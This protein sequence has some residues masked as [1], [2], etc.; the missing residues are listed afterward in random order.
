MQVRKSALHDLMK[1][2]LFEEGPGDTSP[3]QGPDLSQLE[4]MEDE[5]ITTVPDEFPVEPSAQM[6]TQLSEDRPP[7]ED[8]SYL[9]SNSKELGL[10]ADVIGQMV[11]DDQVEFFYRRL[12]MLLEDAVERHNNPDVEE[13]DIEEEVVQVKEGKLRMALRTLL[14]QSP[15]EYDIYRYGTDVPG[16]ESS[17]MDLPKAPEEPVS[18]D[19]LASQ[20]G[21][22]AA[23]GIRQEI[24]RI[25]KRLGFV[26]DNI[27]P[28]DLDLMIHE[29]VT[30]YIETLVA[31]GMI[32]ATDAADLVGS[33]QHVAELDS[34]RFFFTSAFIMPAYQKL[35][36]TVRKN[37]E[38]KVHTMG[39]PKKTQQTV[40]NQA[41]GE[42]PRNFA[43]LNK[44]L[45]KDAAAEGASSEEIEKMK[46]VLFKEFPKLVKLAS[47]EGDLAETALETWRGFTSSKKEKLLIQAMEATT[48]LQGSI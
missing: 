29:A 17:S 45:L 5:L 16:D 22:R 37:I 23:S 1:G 3:A 20:F 21:Y 6:A 24:E 18:L 19:D 44:K 25:L 2:F 36:R 26:A 9:P 7:I 42:T 8:E 47:V 11:P 14:E 31:Q 27:Q 41:L 48:D 28:E 33:P 46:G 35:M 13:I 15:E 34:F 32:D 40:L 39:L 38:A 43:K 4:S 12:H 30:G 10:A